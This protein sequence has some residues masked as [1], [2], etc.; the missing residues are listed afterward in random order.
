M[1]AT[2][3]CN[4]IHSEQGWRFFST[5]SSVCF[6]L[7]HGYLWKSQSCSDFIS[8]ISRNDSHFGGGYFRFFF[9][10]FVLRAPYSLPSSSLCLFCF[11]LFHKLPLSIVGFSSWT[12]GV[13]AEGL[14]PYIMLGT[15]YV[16]I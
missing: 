5:P 15:A 13:L 12:H 16:F 10:L 11:V 14:S 7:F 8:L 2:S 3:I 6:Q 9:G 1:V 4:P